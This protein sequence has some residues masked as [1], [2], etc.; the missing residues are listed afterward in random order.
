MLSSRK[1]RVQSESL[2]TSRAEILR[3]ATTRAA[4]ALKLKNQE[5]AKLLGVSASTITR[6][7]EGRPIEGKAEELAILFVRMFRSLDAV[8]GGDADACQKWLHAENTHLGDRPVQRIQSVE[9]L[10]H[11]TQYLDGMR[12][13]A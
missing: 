3:K 1:H 12:G 2:G 6:V 5:L 7:M 9:G 4:A 8:L 13:K 10:V 11:V